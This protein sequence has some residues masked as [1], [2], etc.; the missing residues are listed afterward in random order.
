MKKNK[1]KSLKK[2]NWEKKKNK[3]KNKR[4]E[5]TFF[6]GGKLYK[7][8]DREITV[9]REERERKNL[10]KKAIEREGKE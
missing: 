6:K 3:K 4:T 7:S 5:K 10:K 8:I 2:E 1:G 9:R